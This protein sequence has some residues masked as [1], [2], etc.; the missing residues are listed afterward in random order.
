M[1]TKSRVGFSSCREFPKHSREK[2]LKRYKCLT[3]EPAE[4]LQE[5]WRKSSST[6]AES[7]QTSLQFMIT[8]LELKLSFSISLCVWESKFRI[9]SISVLLLQI[10]K[11]YG[12]VFH[13][14]QFDKGDTLPIGPPQLMMAITADGQLN[15]ELAAGE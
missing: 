8:E 2:S 13:F 11:T 14:W 5:S 4:F 3:F 10:A 12:K 15:P 6:V 7:S 9:W 1:T